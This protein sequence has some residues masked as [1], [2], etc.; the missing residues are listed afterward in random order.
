ME[1]PTSV[2]DFSKCSRIWWDCEWLCRFK[3]KM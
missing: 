3:I 1:K 2:K